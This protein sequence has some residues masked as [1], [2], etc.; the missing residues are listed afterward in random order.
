ME[1]PERAE[2][3]ER[4]ERPERTERPEKAERPERAPRREKN[5]DEP[6]ETFR[7]EVGHTH[8]V[9]PGNIVGAIANEAGLD[10]EYIGR[11]D[12]REDH[13]FVDLPQGMPKDV[14]RDLQKAW[15]C[16]QQLRISRAGDTPEL[17]YSTP[18]KKAP[19]K[20]MGLGKPMTPRVASGG[21]RISHGKSSHRGPGGFSHGGGKPEHRG[22]KKPRY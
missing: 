1:R 3:P 20:P 5:N 15:V 9:Q 6:T 10:S 22:P 8:G 14:F 2:R 21:Q 19:S 12:I 7:I 4:P 18:P 17:P 13:S 11:I 16:G